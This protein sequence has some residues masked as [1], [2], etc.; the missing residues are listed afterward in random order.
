M[1]F[2]GKESLAERQSAVD[3]FQTDPSVRVFVGSLSAAGVGI[4]LTAASFEV[5]AE[6][7]WVPG[8]MSQAEDRC[9]RIGQ[10]NSV[11]VQHI[12]FEGSLD[13]MIAQT[14]V[15]KQAVIDMALDREAVA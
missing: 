8:V 5:C 4:T 9:H 1:I 3:A 15:R 11:L 7:D 6:L 2:T 14:L 10:R 12:V 13:A